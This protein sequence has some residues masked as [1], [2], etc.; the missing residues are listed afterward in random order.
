MPRK[1]ILVLL[2]LDCRGSELN[3]VNVKKIKVMKVLNYYELLNAVVNDLKMNGMYDVEGG[4]PNVCDYLWDGDC[5]PF[6]NSHL[7]WN[8][9][10]GLYEWCY[11]EL[12]DAVANND[13]NGAA[14]RITDYIVES[15]DLFYEYVLDGVVDNGEDV[16]DDMVEKCDAY[17]K[18][19]NK[20]MLF[21]DMQPCGVTK[22]VFENF[23]SACCEDFTKYDAIATKYSKKYDYDFTSKKTKKMVEAALGCCD[24][25]LSLF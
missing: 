9:A 1:H 24:N 16:L 10:Q 7:A 18:D 6:L 4:Y 13:V 19:I 5:A 14:R 20:Q 8:T 23:L 17:I 3:Q 15:Y 22:R 25:E 11:D 12:A 2:F 21:E